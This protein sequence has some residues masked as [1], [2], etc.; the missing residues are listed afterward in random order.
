[1]ALYAFDGTWNFDQDDDGKDSNVVRFCELYSG[2]T[3]YR[4]G[5]GTRLH[6]LG[7]VMGGIF[8][9]GGHKRIKEMSQELKENWSLGDEVI[10]I[11][12]FSR[13]SA[14]AVHFANKIADEGIH[15]LS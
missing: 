11:I 4:A 3:E 5:V 7:R 6:A 1:M 2:P 8:G 15:I 10:D 9:F 12:G 13:G 14:L